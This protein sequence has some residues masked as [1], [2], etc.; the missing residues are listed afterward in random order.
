MN[1][2]KTI[3]VRISDMDMMKIDFCK[4]ELN[5]NVSEVIRAGVDVLYNKIKNEKERLTNVKGLKFK[6]IITRKETSFRDIHIWNYEDIRDVLEPHFKN[7][8][9]DIVE[10]VVKG[11]TI[12]VGDVY[13]QAFSL[14]S[15]EDVAEAARIEE[16]FNKMLD[17]TE[18]PIASEFMK[19]LFGNK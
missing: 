8:V 3:K 1:K 16:E 14:A 18:I 11:E 6:E 4:N 15:E 12:T 10:R 19:K 2:E 17:A 13:K 7:D 5:Q 9:D